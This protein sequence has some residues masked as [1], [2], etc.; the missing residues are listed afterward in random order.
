V[1]F[2][3]VGYLCAKAGLD[4][5][6]AGKLRQGK[7]SDKEKAAGGDSKGQLSFCVST[8]IALAPNLLSSFKHLPVSSS[9]NGPALTKTPAVE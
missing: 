9:A 3:P 2:T 6:R 7:R 5:L 8:N 4:C 1:G